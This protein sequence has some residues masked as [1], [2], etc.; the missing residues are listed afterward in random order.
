MKNIAGMCKKNI[1][2]HSPAMDE[3]VNIE[4]YVIK[5]PNLITNS[6]GYGTN[7][8]GIEKENLAEFENKYHLTNYRITYNADKTIKEIYFEING[9]DTWIKNTNYN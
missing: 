7:V 3:Y 4:N 1:R 5:D 6:I 9:V 8:W 2:T